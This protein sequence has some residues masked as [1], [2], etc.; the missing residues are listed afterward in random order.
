MGPLAALAIMAIIG[1][2]IF[3]SAWIYGS[4]QA[5]ATKLKREIVL[6]EKKLRVAEGGLKAI[7]RGAGDPVLEAQLA[8]DEITQLEIKELS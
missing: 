2:V 3:G 1:L 6:S 4:K 5:G 7:T 8:L